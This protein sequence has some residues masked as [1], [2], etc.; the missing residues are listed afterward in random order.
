[1]EK[2]FNRE[3]KLM[4]KL[5]NDAGTEQPSADFKSKIMAKIEAKKAPV[6]IYEPLISV[7]VWYVIAFVIASA[8]AVLYFQYFDISI[9][10]SNKFVLS[11]IELPKLA[12]PDLH[13][14]RTALYAIAF[15]SLFF[16]QIP[17]LKKYID[18]QY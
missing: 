4:K 16:L 7:S 11:R 2:Q 10:L 6:K 5:L 15:L 17:F 13:I 12:F 14:S 1:M 3:D 8:V 9:D 18:R